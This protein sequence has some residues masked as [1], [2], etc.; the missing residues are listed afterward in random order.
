[1]RRRRLARLEGF[2]NNNATA[3]SSNAIASTSPNTSESSKAFAESISPSIQQQLQRTEIPMEVEESND[4]QCN[5][6][7]EITNSGIENMEVDES[8]RKD[9]IPRS[10]VSIFTMLKKK[11]HHNLHHTCINKKQ[12]SICFSFSNMVKMAFIIFISVMFQTASSSIEVTTDNIHVVI[13]RVLRISWKNPVEGSIFLP[14]TAVYMLKRQLD[15][16]EII[17]Q[18]LMEVLCMFS[19]DEDPLKDI[20]IDMSSDRQ[21]SPN[22]Q[23]SPLLSPVT[24]LPSYQLPTMPVPTCSKASLPKSLIYLLDCYSR[25]AVEERNHPKVYIVYIYIYIFFFL[26]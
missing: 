7:T 6:I 23:T 13:S 17:N 22:N 2:N 21:D 25:V 4:K 1:M 12:K 3:S 14:Q 18:A 9:L 10:R 24:V 19:K 20:M 8:D 26:N 16:S 15:F 11:K 5:I